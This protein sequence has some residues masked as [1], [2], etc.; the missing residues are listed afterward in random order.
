MKSNSRDFTGEKIH[1][2][3]QKRE[4]RRPL[5]GKE[6]LPGKDLTLTLSIEL[7]QF[8][9]ALLADH[10]ATREKRSLLIHQRLKQPWIKGGH[11]RDGSQNGRD[12]GHGQ[13]AEV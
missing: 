12:F 4:D 6:A 1:S 8:A 9:E 2:V 7:Q 3:D 11:Y 13:Y 5:P 10:E